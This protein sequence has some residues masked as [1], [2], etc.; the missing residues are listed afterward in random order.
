ML[1]LLPI[2][3]RDDSWHRDKPEIFMIPAE[4]R[5]KHTAIFGSTGS[6]KSTLLR[7]MIAWDLSAGTG[8]TV[9][10][11]HGQLV[12]ELLNQHIPRFRKNDVVFFDPKSRS[13]ALGLNVLACPRRE[14][15]GLVVSQVVNIFQKLWAGSW[16]PR[17]EDI[18]RNSLWV[19]IEQPEPL[20]LLA[21][22]RLLADDAYRA[23]LLRHVE[24]PV[25]VDFFTNTLSRWP[26]SLR[27]EAINPVLNKT[28]AF[29]TDPRMRAIIGQS[30][31]SFSFR[32]MMDHRK[33]L[34]CDLAKGTIGDDNSRL[35]GSLIILQEKLAALS[36][37]D[38]SEA[39][40]IPHVLYVEESQSFIGDFESILAEARKYALVLTVVTQ[41]IEALPRE[42]TFSI[43]TNCAT[44]I[45]YRVSAT[46]ATRLANEFGLV[47]PPSVI[48]DLPD[49]TLYVKTLT[50]SGGPSSPSGPH[51]VKAYP[52]FEGHPSQAH[53][54]SVIRVS[55]ARY[56]KLR[57][58][59]DETL[60]REYF[61]TREAA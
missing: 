35:L 30:R 21:L 5:R 16:G 60:T 41:G 47:I 59:I 17:L 33:I 46:D 32:W 9:V 6:G 37:Q 43:F 40:R 3:T 29:I 19:L 61:S 12:E 27:E 55:Q 10:D 58:I 1:D 20:S 14:E 54:E 18:L 23:D 11:P 22:P 50:S 44:V 42:A 36:R 48:Q 13:H 53:R 28:R 2:G 56:A 51:R 15:R 49:Y 34:L 57:T 52:P 31:S 24:N 8:L 25:V 39:Q 38:I 45:S 7:N 26:S 4:T